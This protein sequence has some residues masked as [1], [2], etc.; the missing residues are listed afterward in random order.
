MRVFRLWNR[1]GLPLLRRAVQGASILVMV[2]L[3]LFAL[4]THYKEAR[5]IDDLSIEFCW[6]RLLFDFDEP[7]EQPLA[8]TRA[9]TALVNATTALQLRYL[10]LTIPPVARPPEAKLR[11]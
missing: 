8:A 2:L 5:A 1:W 7:P 11:G 9:R 3:P 10:M 4:Y 6:T